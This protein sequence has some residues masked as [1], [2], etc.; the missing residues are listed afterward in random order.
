[1][2]MHPSLVAAWMGLALAGVVVRA[3]PAGPADRP[4]EVTAQELADLDHAM[5]PVVARAMAGYPDAKR[6]YEAGLPRGQT[7]YVTTRLRDDTRRWEQVYVQVE[8]IRDGFVT[9]TIDSQ[10]RLV[11]GYARGD[12]HRF[13]E[14]A[15]VDW[16]IRYAD[17]RE[18]GNLVGKYLETWQPPTQRERDEW[19]LAGVQREGAALVAAVRSKA[20]FDLDS[21]ENAAAVRDRLAG[22]SCAGLEYTA[23]RVESATGDARLYLLG[24][25][26]AAGTVVLG[27]H[28]VMPIRGRTA[29]LDALRQSTQGCLTTRLRQDAPALVVSAPGQSLP[30]EFHVFINEYYDV[31][32]Y[33]ATGTGTWKI[34][35]GLVI[36]QH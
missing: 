21:L 22:A 29:D 3:D 24:T 5:A 34:T 8:S 14:A 30:S 2:R 28:F 35:A 13:A 4:H 12:R 6:R 11:R 18:E 32:V 19:V 9:G 16:M 15:V 27:R 25:A 36:P 26:D 20:V 7:F 23:Y 31:D 17:G 10:V 1:M 33:V